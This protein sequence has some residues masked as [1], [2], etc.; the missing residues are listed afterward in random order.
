MLRS[1]S[2]R[3]KTI[4]ESLPCAGN[5]SS[6]R[7]LT[8]EC[9]SGSRVLGLLAI[10]FLSLTGCHGANHY[11][12]ESSVFGKQLPASMRLV[13]R[14]KTHSV[15]MTRLAGGAGDRTVAIPASNATRNAHLIF[16]TPSLTGVISQ[17]SPV[18]P[19]TLGILQSFRARIR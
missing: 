1:H 9:F 6:L 15:D 12:A 3:R 16:I 19:F 7:E 17:N 18:V 10:I 13:E 14:P 4:S 11:Y 5:A 8:A 2:D